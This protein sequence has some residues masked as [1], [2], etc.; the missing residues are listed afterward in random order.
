MLK[1]GN[2]MNNRER[3]LELVSQGV[4]SV[5]EGLDLLESLS[6]QETKKTEAKEFTSDEVE[7]KEANVKTELKEEVEETVEEECST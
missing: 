6:S 7:A 1:G 4:L 3:I 2:R 5:E